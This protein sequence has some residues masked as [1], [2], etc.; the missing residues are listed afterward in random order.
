MKH[1]YII[2]LILPFLG[3]GQTQEEINKKL[4]EVSNK[5]NKNCPMVVDQY[6]TMLS[7]YGGLGM[8]MYHVQIDPDN[9]TDYGMSQSEWLELQTQT[10]R[11][12]FCTD[13]SMKSFRDDLKIDVIWKYVDLSGRVIGKVKLNHLDCVE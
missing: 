4:G 7:T 9:F 8:F 2:L 12:I 3:F 5:I 11:T 10:M 13:P 6:T 1:L